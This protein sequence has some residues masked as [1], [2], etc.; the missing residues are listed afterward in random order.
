MDS[1]QPPRLASTTCRI[2]RNALY[3]KGRSRRTPIIMVSVSALRRC[4]L[5]RSLWK[6]LNDKLALQACCL[7]PLAA[8]LLLLAARCLLLAACCLL[9]GRTWHVWRSQR[10]TSY[11]LCCLAG[12]GMFGALFRKLMEPLDDKYVH[13]CG[14]G[15]KV[16]ASIT[17]HVLHTVPTLPLP[18]CCAPYRPAFLPSSLFFPASLTS[19][20]PR[21][22]SHFHPPPP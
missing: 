18:T 17:G 14:K 5:I 8:C 6:G 20:L 19:S 4:R 16:S 9:P 10:P 15:G 2:A 1:P 13:V 12:P 7:L 21:P 22:P 3:E 11:F